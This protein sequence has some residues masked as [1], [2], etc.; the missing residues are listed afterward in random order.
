MND[1]PVPSFCV[2]GG[3][4]GT[5]SGAGRAG[6][7]AGAEAAGAGFGPAL[8]GGAGGVGTGATSG[9]AAGG[10][11]R[12][13]SS[14]LRGSGSSTAQA[15]APLT[16]SSATTQ[17]AATPGQEIR[18]GGAPAAA[19]QGTKGGRPAPVARGGGGGALT[20][21]KS[22]LRKAGPAQRP[23]DRKGPTLRLLLFSVVDGWTA[24]RVRLVGPGTKL[25]RVG[26]C[27]HTVIC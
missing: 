17:A 7:Q 13:V 24:G 14:A 9:S 23:V 27:H 15:N 11:A 21:T 10:S 19:D 3:P 2:S 4:S 8:P 26:K 18:P 20:D 12:T 22:S 6:A 5:G 16:R 25:P 1:P